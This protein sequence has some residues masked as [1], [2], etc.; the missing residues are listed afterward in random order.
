MAQFISLHVGGLGPAG[1]RDFFVKP[2]PSRRL[3]PG[4]D[5]K[6]PSKGLSGCVPVPSDEEWNEIQ[7][8]SILVLAR[9]WC[10]RLQAP[11]ILPQCRL[12]PAICAPWLAGIGQAGS[13]V[14]R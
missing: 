10:V 2:V 7:A 1:A 13:K 14:R 3:R 5:S 4:G 9:F 6:C 8:V 12:A 11:Q